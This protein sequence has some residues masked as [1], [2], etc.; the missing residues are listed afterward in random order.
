LGQ[1]AS[2][3][4]LRM[5]FARWAMVAV[6]ATLLLGT[7]SG[8]LSDSDYGNRW[9]ALLDK[10]VTMPSPA[11]IGLVWTLLYILIGLALAMVLNARG[12]GGRGLALTLWFAQF[13]LNLAWPPVFFGAHQVTAGFWIIVAMFVAAAATAWAFGRI[14]AA[15][16]WLMLPYLLWIAF[17]GVLNY[18]VD[19]LNPDAEALVPAP[20]KTQI[21]L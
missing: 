13:A 8:R 16:G 1:I 20:R 2:H 12:A 4:Q 9:F 10:P 11:V 3:A 7:A 19:Q 14:R 21:R 6:P 5:S 15:A 18:Q 17:A